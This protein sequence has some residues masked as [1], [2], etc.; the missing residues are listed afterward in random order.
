MYA[1]AAGIFNPRLCFNTVTCCINEVRNNVEFTQAFWQLYW[2][3]IHLRQIQLHLTLRLFAQLQLLDT[4]KNI[5]RTSPPPSL[6][7]KNWLHT[8]KYILNW[9]FWIKV[10]GH[11]GIQTIIFFVLYEGNVNL[12]K[13]FCN[14]RHN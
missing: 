11:A 9:N 14:S 6:K 1:L 12:K 13:T 8:P 4:E 2:H 10:S 5:I 3:V 7:K